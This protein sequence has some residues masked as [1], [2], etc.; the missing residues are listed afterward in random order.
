MSRDI[1]GRSSVASQ[2]DHSLLWLIPAVNYGPQNESHSS[3]LTRASNDITFSSTVDDT[4]PS[5]VQV[6]VLENAQTPNHDH[7]H[8]SPLSQSSDIKTPTKL[9]LVPESI[10]PGGYNANERGGFLARSFKFRKAPSILEDAR[11][12]FLQPGQFP[13]EAVIIRPLPPCPVDLTTVKYLPKP[14]NPIQARKLA[15]LSSEVQANLANSQGDLDTQLRSSVLKAF[16][17]EMR[18]GPRRLLRRLTTRNNDRLFYALVGEM[19]IARVQFTAL[20]KNAVPTLSNDGI[21]RALSNFWFMRTLQIVFGLPRKIT[22]SVLGYCMLYPLTDDVLDKPAMTKVDKKSFLVRFMRYITHG[23]TVPNDKYPIERDIW[24][25]F[26]LIELDWDRRRYPLIYR[27]PGELMQVQIESQKQMGGEKHGTPEPEFDMLWDI[28]VRKGALSTL[29][30]AYLVK[31]RLTQSE[32]SYAAHLGPVLQL[33]NDLRGL[34]ED[35]AEGQYTP[36]SYVYLHHQ[37]LDGIIDQVYNLYLVAHTCPEHLAVPGRSRKRKQLFQ[38]MLSAYS[39]KFVQYIAVNREKFSFR[40]LQH[41]EDTSPLPL[42][43]LARM[44]Y[45]KHN[46]PERET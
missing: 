22:N 7:D 38:A 36:F 9:T 3:I 28:T 26:G 5:S 17:P 20:A 42:P 14:I 24:R 31:G 12:T 45:V 1:Y 40:F 6:D 13:G 44:Y 11:H 23:D 41:V 32:A 4:N 2:I 39:F 25:M 37:N 21:R 27:M 33:M 16:G 34:D 43:L 18:K 35:I 30:D 10:L 29:C 19:D 46:K 8:S 15:K